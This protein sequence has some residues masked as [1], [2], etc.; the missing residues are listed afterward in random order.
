MVKSIIKEIIIYNTNQD[1]HHSKRMDI[2]VI[3]SFD[4]LHNL[5]LYQDNQTAK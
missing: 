2:P 3:P 5:S 4:T 1:I